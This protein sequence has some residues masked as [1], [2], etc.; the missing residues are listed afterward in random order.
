MKPQQ[1]ETIL[2]YILG[3]NVKVDQ[4]R[5]IHHPGT[6]TVYRI[7]VVGRPEYLLKSYPLDLRPDPG[8]PEF[9]RT[10][11]NNLD[12]VEPVSIICKPH[13]YGRYENYF[14][15]DYIKGELLEHVIN[16][17]QLEPDQSRALFRAALS[18][19]VNI[20]TAAAQV[21]DRR[22]LRRAFQ[23]DR[24]DRNL[25][26]SAQRIEQ[27]GFTAYEQRG[28]QVSPRWREA[29]RQF[30]RKKVL[31]ALATT[32]SY[33]LGHGD[34][35]P[36]NLVVTKS[37]RIAVI[38]WLGMGKA[39][40]WF[41]VAYLLNSAL[42]IHRSEHLEYYLH[43]MQEKSFLSGLTL[44]GVQELMEVGS[45]YQELIRARSNSRYIGTRT[46]PHHVNEFTAALNG[47][48]DLVLY[49]AKG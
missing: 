18:E 43:L 17:A 23:P 46:N 36:N 37:G 1:A 49:G 48:A 31:A 21:G 38:D 35:K 13:Y 19:L 32:D 25:N 39:Q 2:A 9:W 7:T 10:E 24:L 15:Q 29:L 42:P 14:L 34:Y 41:D 11:S 4:L 20:H 5:Q 44:R 12:N 33:V 8:S 45:I 30:P 27:I 3:Q 22:R 28:Y 26:K 40:P 47:L 6:G 16:S